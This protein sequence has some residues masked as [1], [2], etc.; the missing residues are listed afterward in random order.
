MLRLRLNGRTILAFVA[1]VLALVAAP[2][3]WALT[4]GSLR[5]T[6]VDTDMELPIPGVVLTL[7]GEN[8]I[9]GKQ[10]NATDANGQVLFVK[11]P[12]GAYQVIA[13]KAGFETVTVKN[14]QVN[15]NRETRQTIQMPIAGTSEDITIEAKAKAVDVSD[16]T[17]SEVLTK[18]FLQR[19]PSGR[20]YQSAVQM[21]SGVTGG[22]GNPNIGGGAYNENTYMLDGANITDPVTGTFSLN[23]N[24][25]AIEQIEVML[26]GYMPEY[27]V[28]V[29]GIVNLVTES[30]TNNL[31]F[32]SSIF[33]QNG[34]WAP[35]MDTR[36]TADG[37][38]L[39]PT[40]FDSHFELLSINGKVS[41]P[42][43]RDR[44]WFIISYQHARSIIA[45]TGIAQPR[46]YDAH[47]VLTKLTVQPT[48][49][50]RFTAFV[51]LD[52]TTIDNTDQS[53]PFTRAEAQGRQAQGGFVSQARWQ[54][55]MSPDMNLDTM[56]VIQKSYLE[57]NAV[58]CTH[59]SELGYHPCEPGEL[60]GNVDW[61]TPG[62][63]GSFGAFNSINQNIYD[64]DDRWRL[65][66]SS[67][68]SILSVRDPLGGTH[69]LKFGIEAQQ[70][71]WDKLFGITGNMYFVDL[72]AVAYDPSSFEN[73]Y[74]IETSGP[75]MYR[76][77]GSQWNMF[78]Q[79]SWKPVSNLTI[80][81][82][83]R[84]DS[85]VMRN[86]LG[87]PTISGAILGPRL[88]AAWDPF[89]DQR[90][91]IA[92]GYGRFNDT[93]RLAVADFTSAGSLGSKLFLGEYFANGTYGFTN[94]AS[95]AYDFA[96]DVNYSIRH[97]KMRTPSVDEV[98]LTIEREIIEDVA[99][100]SSM[101]GKFT[102]YMYEPD[103]MNLVYD[104]DG[105]SQ[106]GSRIGNPTQ[107][108]YRMRTPAL[109]K[110][111]YF[112]WDLGLRKIQSRRW[113]GEITYTYTQ[114]IGSSLNA[115]SG[116]F[117]NG[118]QTRYNYGPL[119]TDLR[120]VVKGVAFW[121]LPTD[122]WTASL[123]A[124]FQYYS[125]APDER[126]YWAEDYRGSPGAYALRIEPRG[127]YLRFN[128]WWELGIKYQQA[129]DVRKGRVI[130]DLEATN[131]FNNRAPYIPNY[132]MLDIE[133]RLATVA[134]QDPLRLQAGLR[135][136]F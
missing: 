114:S 99:A 12:P 133:N 25:D 20:S 77:T 35:K 107:T 130:I 29:G 39:A 43:V 120:H 22:G 84:F 80:N 14:L 54:W 90:T 17:R 113:A 91:K 30:G 32:D 64:F 132:A 68:L 41:G 115:N 26:G 40:G 118:P 101:S 37:L 116:S 81:Y 86:D 93:G 65:N 71:I 75:L 55:F 5:I 76:T 131:I 110:R 70:L 56:A 112:Q 58:P 95:N 126:L 102:R 10:E 82:G 66:L 79:D 74:W 50:H 117:V 89:N 57:R 122:P 23:F 48:T 18:D 111:D 92:G 13:V 85:F 15:V 128:P 135:Y 36:Y 78:A 94:N 60:E 109:A 108:R 1:M 38:E 96:P 119:N 42:V 125:G 44:A 53:D 73:Y 3:A 28:S 105:S 45:N 127:T 2:D 16:S 8:L 124:F 34:N 33:Y 134:R 97:H 69:D 129:I 11:L 9:G 88:F 51:Q 21:A 87:E 63:L 19:V 62:R 47:Y 52:P 121:D 27:G 136:Q 4:T 31:E 67:K 104:S 46:D 98:I 123:G 72:N 49:E 6:V 103:E 24:F 7:S 100:F 106:I 61:E 59:N 83:T